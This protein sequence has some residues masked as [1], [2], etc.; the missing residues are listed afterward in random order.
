MTQAAPQNQK[1]QRNIYIRSIRRDPPDLK[2]LSKA[3]I[4]LAEDM[5]RRELTPVES[6][7][8]DASLFRG[9]APFY[10]RYRPH[11]PTAVTGLIAKQAG[12]D[13]SGRML[14]VGCG[15]GQFLVAMSD[16][17]EKLVGLDPDAEMLKEA[18]RAVAKEKLRN[19]VVLLRGQAPDLP[20]KYRPY[21]MIT[22]SRAF[23]WVDQPATARAALELLEPDGSVA[24][25]GDGSFW[26][27]AVNWQRTVRQVVERWLGTER[28]AGNTTY[29][30]P[31]S[32]FTDVLRAAG[33]ADIREFRINDDRSWTIES[34][35]GYLYS[36]SFA[37]R[38]L[39][40]DDVERFEEDL[41]RA[42]DK[43][44]PDGRFEERARFDI[45]LAKKPA[46]A[47]RA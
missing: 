18:R 47:P 21:R 44:F 39:F 6:P 9:T 35:I 31:A 10:A 3:L 37:R 32:R 11:I 41:T 15:T 33:F 24:I 23:H 17:F 16:Y 40:G 20:S 12:L 36:T 13:W 8:Y 22:F 46:T 29:V 30:E 27:G 38:E 5:A 28:K 42:L 1:P 45:L 43:E 7:R 26:T 25:L 34:I 14:D 4:A 2:L 19:K